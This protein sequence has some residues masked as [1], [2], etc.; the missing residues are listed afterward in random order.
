M[1]QLAVI[2]DRLDRESS[3]VFITADLDIVLVNDEVLTY[4][5]REIPDPGV[6][7]HAFIARPLADI[8]PDY[9][10]PITGETLREVAA[11][12]ADT[13]IRLREDIQLRV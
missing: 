3:G 7:K 8:A 5:G 1:G 9:V 12:L 6:T 4:A 13:P 10:H 2:E 11:R